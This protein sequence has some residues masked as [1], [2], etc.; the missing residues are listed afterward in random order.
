MG[1]FEAEE[2]PAKNCDLRRSL[3]GCAQPARVIQRPDVV[4]TRAAGRNGRERDRLAAG[5]EQAELVLEYL[6][7]RK[8]DLLLR[9]I[10]CNRIA[11]AEQ[12]DLAA[13]PGFVREDVQPG[14]IGSDQGGL[15]QGRALVRSVALAPQHRDASAVAMLAQGV[16]RDS[17]RLARPDDDDAA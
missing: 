15:G 17:R 9:R 10:Q 3:K 7:V 5:G 11:A 12:V 8:A 1:D 14:G 6:P 16:C 4:H 2:P 13:R